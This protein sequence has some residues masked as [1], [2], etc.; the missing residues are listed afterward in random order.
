MVGYMSVL[1]R[2]A[3]IRS[4]IWFIISI[5]I[6][7]LAASTDTNILSEPNLLNVYVQ[8]PPGGPLNIARRTIE[9]IPI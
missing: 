1:V 9:A 7:V 2:I 6:L 5:Q 8:H 4:E 3:Y